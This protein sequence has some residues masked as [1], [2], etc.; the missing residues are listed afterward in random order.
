MFDRKC[1]WM[2]LFSSAIIVCFSAEEIN[3]SKVFN[4]AA[5]DKSIKGI[6]YHA[7]TAHYRQ[8][9]SICSL[10]PKCLSFDHSYTFEIGECSFYDIGLPVLNQTNKLME[11]T[12][13]N[14]YTIPIIATDCIDWYRMGHREDGVYE[15]YLL[16]KYKRRVYCLMTGSG[17]GWMAFQRRFD[18]S[19]QFFGRNWED[20]KNG[21]GDSDGEYYLGNE[22]LHLLTTSESHDY[23]VQAHAKDGSRK[24]KNIHNVR[25]ESEEEN[26]KI[27]YREE[28]IDS[29]SGSG[30]NYGLV[31]RGQDFLTFD[32]DRYDC[33]Q[34]YGGWW[35][36][37]CHA[38]AMNGN[39]IS[40]N[41][42][43][44]IM[45]GGW[46]GHGESLQSCLLMVR[47]S[48]FHH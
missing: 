34:R 18:G 48:S 26:Y 40:T 13:F 10:N 29:A 14:Y 8:C 35:H 38:V 17:G 19:V 47:R 41:H 42:A 1:I 46:K 11:K 12:G 37:K 5:L 4:L 36:K 22:L 3:G 9:F 32:H 20:F 27:E 24:R 6:P 31:M 28:D 23:M 44:G 33:A 43:N 30:T 15:V 21:F 45:W 2:F 39:Y 25:I 16:A 7:T